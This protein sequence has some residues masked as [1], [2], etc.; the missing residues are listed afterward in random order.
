[1]FYFYTVVI[2]IV[3]VVLGYFF[4]K[5]KPK[6]F[7]EYISL[8]VQS[9]PYL[10]CYAFFIYFLEME[11][12]INIGWGFYTLIFFLLPIAIIALIL[13]LFFWFKQK[14]STV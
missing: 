7:T 11:H 12:Y 10:F 4:K 6:F 5:P 1:M 14:G 8:L 13:K 2:P 3:I 9:L